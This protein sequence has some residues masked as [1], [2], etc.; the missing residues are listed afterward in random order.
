MVGPQHQGHQQR[1]TP[2][3]LFAWPRNPSNWMLLGF[4]GIAAFFLIAEHRAHL[5]GWQ[6]YLLLLACPL[7]MFM[8]GVRGGHNG[9]GS[10]Q[11]PDERKES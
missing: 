5:L 7:M 11:S 1:Q 8:H 6:P 4:L 10:L 3:G 9:R 2:R